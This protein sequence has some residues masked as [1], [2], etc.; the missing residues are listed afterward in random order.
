MSLSCAAATVKYL[1]VTHVDDLGYPAVD[2]SFVKLRTLLAFGPSRNLL[3]SAIELRQGYHQTTIAGRECLNLNK[4]DS[5][6]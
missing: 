4:N 2:K 1:V 5:S 3:E 6:Y